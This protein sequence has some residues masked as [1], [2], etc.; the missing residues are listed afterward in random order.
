MESSYK[1]IYF[2]L[3]G[4]V[5]DATEALEHGKNDDALRILIDA[6]KETEEAYLSL[7][8]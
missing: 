5:A 7:T 8:E 1:E 3:F 4:R 2:R 6:Q